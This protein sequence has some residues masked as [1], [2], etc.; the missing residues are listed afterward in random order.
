M[1]DTNKSEEFPLW[2]PAEI[3]RFYG[4]P[5]GEL[6]GAGQSIAIISL[7]GRIDPAELEKDFEK[8]GV[9]MPDLRVVEI[10]AVP[11][12]Q[13]QD[14]MPT[15]ETH[16]DA[17]VVGSICPAARITI[18]R[19]GQDRELEGLA[20][21]V[22]AAI[23]DDNS[24][25]SISWGKI[26]QPWHGESLLEHALEHARDQGISVCASTGDKSASEKREGFHAV[27][28]EDGSVWVEYPASS[29]WVL[30]CG[31]TELMKTASGYGEKVW[32]N[33]YEEKG[34]NNGYTTATGGGVSKL[35]A[36]P[37]WQTQAGIEIASADERKTGRVV[38]DVAG[39]AAGADWQIYLDSEATPSGGTSAVAPLFASL[40]T[41]ANQKRGE[42][43]KPRLGFVNER[44]YRLAA[45]RDVFNDITQGNNRPTADYPGYDA[46]PGF[47][48]CTGWGTPKAAELIDALAGL[49]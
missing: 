3:A 40:I 12:S 43:G 16:L 18:Y 17:E 2:S 27:A 34:F 13:S 6:D 23:A 5:L 48:A 38:P 30:A 11:I 21:A 41:L 15:M 26:E 7:G 39:L 4:F 19:A 35:F 36:M 25:I 8:L 24:V 32:N 28:R 20:A 1:K 14:Q 44:L 45:E 31:G 22:E 10:D 42:A 46:V 37:S 9:S 29:P 47:D 33:S 49:D